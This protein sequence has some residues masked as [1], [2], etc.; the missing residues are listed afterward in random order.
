MALLTTLF[1]SA[2]ITA[3]IPAPECPPDPRAA[4]VPE[5]LY[6]YDSLDREGYD[7]AL[8]YLRDTLPIWVENQHRRRSNNDDIW[9]GELSMAHLNALNTING[10]MLK[11]E[12]ISS[13][14]QEERN[15]REIAFCQ[16]ISK[17]IVID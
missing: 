2:A 7:W 1:I 6:S 3:A 14:S 15:E 5:L 17:E 13:S 4:D 8:N 10:Y 12:Y 11:L 16:F 9:F